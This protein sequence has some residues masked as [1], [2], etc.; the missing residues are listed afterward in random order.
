MA[1]LAYLGPRGTFSEEA[2]LRYRRDQTQLRPYATWPEI[3]EALAGGEVDEA[4]VALEN[5]CEGSVNLTLDFLAGREDVFIRAELVLPVVQNLLARPGTAEIGK[6]YSHPQALAQ[7]YRYLRRNLPRAVLVPA[8][9]TAAAARKA[10]AS[11]GTAAIGTA[12]AAGLYGLEVR[13]AAINDQAENVT[14]F[15]VLGR[16]EA[17]R[18]EGGTKTSLVVFIVD[19]PGAL[20]RILQ[21]FAVR[22]LNLTRIESRPT[23]NRLGEYHFFIDVIGHR[24]DP[25]VAEALRAVS[26]QSA[27]VRLLGS[28]P[29][30]SVPPVPA[31]PANLSELRSQIDAID[32]Q[33]VELLGR[34][35]A[36]MQA[37]ARAKEGR[38]SFRDPGRE[39]EVLNRIREWARREGIDPEVLAGVYRLLFPYFVHLQGLMAEKKP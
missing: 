6:V 17:A 3:F 37:V 12:R 33:I 23:G 7:C 22:G 18:G 1:T 21:E 24:E 15:V 30:E 31:T 10:A 9:S 8:E 27:R 29:A 34:R 38:P 19:R 35:A 20:Y 2:A 26:S 11:D 36:L 5:S 16:G 25:P 28:Y 13:A 32:R 14:R 4:V 39:E